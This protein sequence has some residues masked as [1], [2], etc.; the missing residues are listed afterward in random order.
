MTSAAP[1]ARATRA[2]ESF[3]T[4]GEAIG[5]V[6]AGSAVFCIT[7]GQWSIIDAILHVLDQV[8]PA[9]ISLWTWTVAEYE[10]QVLT[11]LMQ[12]KRLTGATLIIDQG[13]RTK[14]ARVSSKEHKNS[15]IIGEWKRYFGA[16]S[17][18]YTLNHS[19]STL[20]RASSNST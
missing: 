11:R 6:S 16:D 5:L 3:K 17:V 18:R 4:A 2:N 7:R 19:T 12:D 10:V 1:R 9:A 8:G 14:N 15:E 13:T 20:T